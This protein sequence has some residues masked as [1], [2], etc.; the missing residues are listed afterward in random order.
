MR[1]LNASD[2]PFDLIWSEGALFVMG[3]REGLTAC[4]S[5]LAPGGGLA[6]SEMCWLRP[7][8]PATCRQFFAAAYPALADIETNLA[9]IRAC[10]YE[11]I[12]HFPQPESAWWE[13]YYHRRR[14]VCSLRRRYAPSRRLAMVE[15]I[16]I[17]IDLYRR[18]SAFYGYRILSDDALMRRPQ[19]WNLGLLWGGTVGHSAGSC[20]L[21]E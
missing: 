5:L 19:A 16:Q 2:G 8:P 4:R 7:D 13:L 17:E 10:G 12:G 11:V 6:A 3:F 20:W 9:S 21:P 18:Y 14:S 15:S 1:S